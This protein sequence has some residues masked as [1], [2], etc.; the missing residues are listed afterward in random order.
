[1][2]GFRVLPLLLSCLLLS[3]CPDKDEVEVKI[4]KGTV[5][6]SVPPLV[7][8]ADQLRWEGLTV[9]TLIDPGQSPA[10][11][12]PS[13]GRV[14][15][16]AAATILFRTG[17]PFEDRVVAAVEKAGNTVVVDLR[18]GVELLKFP[19][20]QEDPHIWLDPNN[21]MI[22]ARTM[23]AAF[24][25][26]DKRRELQVKKSLARVTEQ[27]KVLDRELEF[28]LTANRGAELFI[29]HGALGYLCQ[30]YKLKQTALHYQGR[31]PLGAMYAPFLDKVVKQ[32]N[33]V[34]FYEKT[35]YTRQLQASATERGVA[36]IGL[37]LLARDLPGTLRQ[38]VASFREVAGMTGRMPPGGEGGEPPM[39]GGPPP[40]PG[41]APPM[42]GGGKMPPPP[43]PGGAH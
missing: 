20:G 42:P 27:L 38:L 30:R 39:P 35:L 43:M 22:L 14:A 6:V 17:L 37:D 18:Q 26:L 4:V 31:M 33:R 24:I 41:G 25:A 1:M 3:A 5:F 10:I 23:A 32:G 13:P 29:L 12:S 28:S 36:L 40:M 11:T 2:R 9:R 8:L 16:A 34:L 19:G 21:A 15:A 7:F